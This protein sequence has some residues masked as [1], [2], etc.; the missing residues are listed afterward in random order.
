M[1]GNGEMYMEGQILLRSLKL[2]NILS[3]GSQGVEIELQPLNVLVGPNG[4]GKSNFIE[5][6]RLLR[7]C[8]SDLIQPIIQGGGINEW[9][10]KG[11]EPTK[12]PFTHA[13]ICADANN[14]FDVFA[15]EQHLLHIIEFSKFDKPLH[16]SRESIDV[17]EDGSSQNSYENTPFNH[18]INTLSYEVNKETNKREAKWTRST[19]DAAK[20][21]SDQ[22]ILSQRN[23]PGAYPSLATLQEAYQA[24]R[25]FTDV[26][27]GRGS[28]PRLPQNADADASFLAEDYS[29]LALVI[30][31]MQLNVSA[32]RRL[33]E[34]L[35]LFYE[36]VENIVPR[37]S[38]GT[39][40]LYFQE[41]GLQQLVPAT[42]LSDGT[43]RFLCLLTILCHPLPPPLICI[44]EPE[45]GMH[46]DILPTLAKLLI[47]A[48][49][50]TQL[51][52]T[53]HSD[54]LLSEFADISECVIVCD[55]D[56]NGTSLKHLDK[57]AL[58]L[59]LRDYSL[60]EAWLKNAF[61]GTR[62]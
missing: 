40:Q 36:R 33:L 17:F 15:D 61:G 38:Y 30:N 51:I 39:V 35:K 50:R 49:Q 18:S 8:P 4:S 14:I 19:L 27:F 31:E 59:W 2:Q 21:K 52:V 43:L 58:Q 46:P 23:D 20:L 34:T 45:L 16:I 44:E 29:N 42:R 53:T 25:F 3:Y 47:E 54:I 32:F 37:I 5:A 56:D 60:G 41:E 13:K 28:A 6:L 7:A 62:W 48:S 10:W 55:R 24:F 22:S 57:E 11:E 9:I 1:V 26:P 12:Y